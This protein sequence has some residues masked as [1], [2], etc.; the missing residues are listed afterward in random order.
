MWLQFQ[1][2]SIIYVQLFGSISLTCGVCCTANNSANVRF[3]ICKDLFPFFLKISRL[4]V[5]RLL[6]ES[7]EIKM[8]HVSMRI[9]FDLEVHS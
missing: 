1:F 3:K 9:Q 6:E 7:I 2:F 8:V 5:E 4:N